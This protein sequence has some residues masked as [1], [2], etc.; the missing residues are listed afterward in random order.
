MNRLDQ[1]E[2]RIKEIIEKGSDLFPWADQSSAL[3]SHF[4]EALRQFLLENPD[5]LKGSPVRV[6]VSMP[7]EE[8]R[9]WKQHPEGQ[10]L[11]QEVFIETV[12]EMNCKPVLIPEVILQPRN[13]L[14][15]SSMHFLIEANP[16][17]NEKTASIHLKKNRHTLDT[18][19][20][21]S[22]ITLFNLEMN[23]PLDKPVLNLGRRNTNDIVIND[24]RVSRL[25]AQIRK[26]REGYMIFDVGSTGGTFV[27]SERISSQI[28]RTG[29]VIS[30][31]G[32]TLVFSDGKENETES[33]RE[34]TSEISSQ[35]DSEKP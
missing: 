13:S 30:L 3:V 9:L 2:N 25:H 22:G 1:I 32:Y 15:S 35:N 26:T 19:I 11:L 7:A 5:C 6:L 20:E 21:A 33:D 29:D 18:P 23:I 16:E 17:K 14:Q 31:A 12:T 4:C 28:L 27:N 8:I 24:R 34:I 10:K